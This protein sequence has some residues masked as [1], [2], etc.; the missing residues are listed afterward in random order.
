VVYIAICN[1]LFVQFVGKWRDVW[2]REKGVTV[3][4]DRGIV[5]G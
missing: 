4:S 5:E 3:I 1:G 2:G